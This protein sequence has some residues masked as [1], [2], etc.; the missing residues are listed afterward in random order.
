MNGTFKQCPNGHYY[1][2]DHCPYCDERQETSFLED[3]VL[4]YR[5]ASILRTK[6]D[7]NLYLDNAPDG[8]E[9][10]VE[11]RRN[12]GHQNLLDKIAFEAGCSV[13]EIPCEVLDKVESIKTYIETS[14]RT[15]NIILYNNDSMKGDYYVSSKKISSIIPQTLLTQILGNSKLDLLYEHQRYG[16]SHKKINTASSFSYEN[17]EHQELIEKIETVKY[18]AIALYGKE[19]RVLAIPHRE[20]PKVCTSQEKFES[21]DMAI[22]SPKI[23]MMRYGEE[24]GDA[25]DFNSAVYASNLADVANDKSLAL[26]LK[27]SRQRV[28]ELLV[29][30]L[31]QLAKLHEN[32]IIHCDLKPQNILCL[33]NGLVPIDAIGVRDGDVS[34][35]MTSNYC[36]PEQILSLP[37]S[38]ATDIYNFG[39]ILL[40]VIDGVICGKTSDYVIPVGGTEV[41]TVK[42]LDAPMLYIDS[43]KS[44]IADIK[45]IPYWKSFLEKC[46]AFDSKN[47]YPNVEMC[48]REYRRL[49]EQYPLCNDFFFSP[50]FGRLGWVKEGEKRKVAWFVE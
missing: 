1:Q 36:A 40:S 39:L 16:N 49:L 4:V 25:Y 37:V 22:L 13:E 42:L 50:N 29:T 33:E 9:R 14:L 11:I 47:R 2:G 48:K 6:S 43:K 5:D 10:F 38:P 35:G 27:V 30:L 26:R 41:R 20:K 24:L 44:N 19:R 32:G 18:L 45:G 15:K 28:A 31:S 23:Y 17:N 3:G 8:V 46:L 7:V 12:R 21:E 34:V